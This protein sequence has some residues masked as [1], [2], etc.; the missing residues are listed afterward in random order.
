MRFAPDLAQNARSA[1]RAATDLLVAEREAR[2]FFTV[3][4]LINVSG[5]VNREKMYT[6]AK[7]IV[8]MWP[9]KP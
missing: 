5:G 3:L 7:P 8:K 9:Y 2:R 6:F 4:M 1:S